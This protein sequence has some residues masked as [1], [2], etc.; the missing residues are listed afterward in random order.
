MLVLARLKEQEAKTAELDSSLQLMKTLGGVGGG[1]MDDGTG[2]GLLD[3]LEILVDNLRKECYAKFADKDDQNEMQKKMEELNDRLSELE[4]RVETDEA[5]LKDCKDQTDTNR[6][7]IEDILAKL[8]DLNTKLNGFEGL[9]DLLNRLLRLEEEMDNKLDKID[10]A[11]EVA[12]L[13]EMIGNS[14]LEDKGT[15]VKVTGP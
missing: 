13:R 8:H 4:Q 9:E 14:V 6:L 15:K 12:R 10:F 2:K 3:A 11:N 7:D 1:K 5:L